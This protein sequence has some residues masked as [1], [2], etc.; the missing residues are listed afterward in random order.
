VCGSKHSHH[1]THLRYGVY[2]ALM[3]GPSKGPP[4]GP[5]QD[6]SPRYC[7]LKHAASGSTIVLEMKTEYQAGLEGLTTLARFSMAA[8]KELED[9]S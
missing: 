9:E 2:V 1:H 8:A 5:I 4:P 3:L 6:T 7:D